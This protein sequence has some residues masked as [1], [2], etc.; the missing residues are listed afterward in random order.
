MFT[1]RGSPRLTWW[2]RATASSLNMVSAAADE[3]EMVGDVGLG[4]GTS[5]CR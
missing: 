2:M 5:A 4:F 3:T 1:A